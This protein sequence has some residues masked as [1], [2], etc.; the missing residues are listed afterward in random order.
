MQR[1]ATLVP[2]RALTAYCATS[3]AQRFVNKKAAEKVL[4][5]EDDTR[6]LEAEIDENINTPEERYAHEREVRL[7]KQMV[8]ELQKDHSQKMENMKA[9]R[10]KEVADLKKQMTSLE[11]R[12]KHIQ[13]QKD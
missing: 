2:V 3:T 8:G 10:D 12:L 7:L 11:A 4:K 5:N 9:A 6:W 13:G 1:L